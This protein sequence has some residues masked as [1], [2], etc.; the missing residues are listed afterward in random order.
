[1]IEQV[2]VL[3]RENTETE[4]TNSVQLKQILILTQKNKFSENKNSQKRKKK[5][6]FIIVFTTSKSLQF[7][8]DQK[9]PLVS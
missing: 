5:K 8:S 7:C 9:F 6:Q 1:M 3:G 4:Q 2:R